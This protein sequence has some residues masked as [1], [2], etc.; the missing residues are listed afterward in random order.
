VTVVSAVA[1]IEA[2]SR[3]V[4]MAVVGTIARRGAGVKPRRPRFC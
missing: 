4:L 1:M 2:R 3:K